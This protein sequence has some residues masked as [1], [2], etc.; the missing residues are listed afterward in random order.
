MTRSAHD[1][2]EKSASSIEARSPVSEFSK[3][4]YR[5]S[6]PFAG[7]GS[8]SLEIFFQ[9]ARASVV[10]IKNEMTAL[11]CIFRCPRK[12]CTRRTAMARDSDSWVAQAFPPGEPLC[13]T[14]DL[15]HTVEKM[16][17]CFFLEELLSFPPGGCETSGLALRTVFLDQSLK[18]RIVPQR[19]PNRIYFQALDR[20]S[21]RSAQQTIQNFDH[22][23]VVA[24]NGVNFGTPS[25]NF[26]AAEG[27]LAFRLQFGRALRRRQRGVLFVEVGKD[28]CQLNVHFRVIGVPFQLLLDG[29]FC[30]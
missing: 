12:K 21:A 9:S 13:L 5:C 3:T 8:L 19:V 6:R 27:V 25:R 30:P 28:F 23:S 15:N 7:D 29:A 10:T 16:R 14:C 26:R 4:R 20:D 2:A 22:A 24:K 11:S 18:T 17:T 1:F